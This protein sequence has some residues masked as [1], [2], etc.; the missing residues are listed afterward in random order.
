MR[1]LAGA[2]GTWPNGIYHHVGDREA[3][4][5]QVLERVV[6]QM[7]VPPAS[8]PWQQW[9]RS[10]LHDGRSVLEQH[11]GSA[12]R[13]CRD[14]PGVPAAAVIIDRGV[15]LLLDA[16]FGP[17]APAAYSLALNSTLL[18]IATDDA[19]RA[20]GQVRS[21]MAH[22][23]LAVPDPPDAG[24]GWA[25]MREAMTALAAAPA[26]DDGS[27]FFA[28]TVERTIDGLKRQLERLRGAGEGA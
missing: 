8:V 5:R 7:P 25:A 4:V 17:E 23:L 28:Y 22:A 19:R 14:G 21:D 16:G 20:S 13:L 3:V 15:G 10:F 11:P 1:D 12:G 27:T 2:L 18:L 6:R 26:N 9:F 24:R